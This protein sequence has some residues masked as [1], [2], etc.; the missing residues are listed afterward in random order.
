MN[1]EYVV[2]V[3]LMAMVA[4]LI[5]YYCRNTKSNKDIGKLVVYFKDGEWHFYSEQPIAKIEGI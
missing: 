5:T 3:A 1:I 2:A 4:G